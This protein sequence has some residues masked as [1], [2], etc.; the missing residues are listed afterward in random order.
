[1]ANPEGKLTPEQYAILQV[2][3][4]CSETGATVAELW[5]QIIE[6]RSVAR[7]T[8]LKQVQRL[9]KRGW[10]RRLPAEGVTRYAAAID[11]EVAAR[12]LAGAF[13]NDFFDGSVSEFVMSLLGTSK[14]KAGQVRR[15]RKLLDEHAAQRRSKGKP[16]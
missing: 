6:Q 2:L 14:L 3:W 7:T 16:S 13:V 15:L 12:M 9:E 4:K 11:R 5:D 8:V 10:V 1:M